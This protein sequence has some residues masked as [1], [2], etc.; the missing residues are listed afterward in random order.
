MIFK[1]SNEYN[2]N[3]KYKVIT[4][5]GIKLKIKVSEKENC[6]HHKSIYNNIIPSG[7]LY[8]EN[9]ELGLGNMKIWLL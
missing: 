5:C 4:L 8:R 9:L 3:K 1:I 7:I 2:E 6:K